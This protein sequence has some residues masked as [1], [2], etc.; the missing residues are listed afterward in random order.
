MS[1]AHGAGIPTTLLR[2][3]SNRIILSA[4]NDANE[5]TPNTNADSKNKVA[6]APQCCEAATWR[7]SEMKKN[8]VDEQTQQELHF[9]FEG[10]DSLYSRVRE[11]GEE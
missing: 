6:A 3:M 11:M 2:N 10:P 4:R 9:N 5:N 1:L 7:T 8:V